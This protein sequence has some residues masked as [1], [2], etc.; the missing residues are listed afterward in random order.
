[1]P[2]W[3]LP[4]PRVTSKNI[5]IIIFWNN[6]NAVQCYNSFALSGAELIVVA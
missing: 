4:S 5:V 6:S 3:K 2:T 1:M